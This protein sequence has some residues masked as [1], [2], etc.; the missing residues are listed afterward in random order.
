MLSGLTGTAQANNTLATAETGEPDHAGN[1]GGHSVWYRWTAPVSGHVYFLTCAAG[2]DTVLAV[3]RG[4]TLGSL[5]PV[6]SND[7]APA[8]C[9]TPT[10]SE[11]DFNA[12]SGT[13]YRIAVDGAPGTG[14]LRP[15]PAGRGQRAL[16]AGHEDHQ[17]EDPQA[18][19]HAQL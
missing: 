17:A 18:Q 4:Q 9:V 12:V 15:A 7:N 8:F 14:G 11:V 1:A 16:G 2:F 10:A 6:A 13:T 3:Y 5:I 19:G